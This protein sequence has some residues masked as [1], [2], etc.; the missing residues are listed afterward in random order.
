MNRASCN[1]S[2]A[3]TSS[4]LAFNSVWYTDSAMAPRKK[5]MAA[6]EQK[7]DALTNK[8]SLAEREGALGPDHP[9]VG[10]SLNNLAA[11]S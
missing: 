8:R 7:I 9:N 4:N 10:A 2:D 5:R 1:E 6:S 3:I 11:G